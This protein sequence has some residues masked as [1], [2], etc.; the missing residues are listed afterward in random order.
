MRKVFAL[1]TLAGLLSVVS[2][3]G[4]TEGTVDSMAADSVLTPVSEVVDSLADTT[5]KVV[6]SLVK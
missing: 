3:G 2:C 4:S 5:K 1:L 6:D